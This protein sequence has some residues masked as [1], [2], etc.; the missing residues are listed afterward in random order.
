MQKS[1]ELNDSPADKN[2]AIE[3]EWSEIKRPIGLSLKANTTIIDDFGSEEL[4]VSIKPPTD[5]EGASVVLTPDAVD[6][7]SQGNPEIRDEDISFEVNSDSKKSSKDLDSN[8][9]AEP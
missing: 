8:N 4:Q 2:A 9:T 5:K 7:K 6:S 3:L 1:S